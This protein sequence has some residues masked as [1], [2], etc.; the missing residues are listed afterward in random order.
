MD[1]C[2]RDFSLLADKTYVRIT[3]P[4]KVRP[5]TGRRWGQIVHKTVERR[6]ILLLTIDLLQGNL[7][8]NTH[9]SNIILPVCIRVGVLR[10]GMIDREIS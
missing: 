7:T 6:G 5:R 9:F 8:V 3:F 1:G 2:R 10:I 4:N